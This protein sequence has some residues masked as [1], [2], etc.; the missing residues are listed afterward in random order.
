[1]GDAYPR[2]EFSPAY[3]VLFIDIREEVKTKELSLQMVPQLLQRANTQ[4]AVGK[5]TALPDQAA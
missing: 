3:S 1:M 2:A 4:K 5:R